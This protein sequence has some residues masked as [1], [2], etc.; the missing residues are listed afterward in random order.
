MK[1]TRL[2]SVLLSALI[3]S[4][5]GLAHA[6]DA[7]PAAAD[8]PAQP[9]Q[10]DS[11]REALKQKE[12]DATSEKNLQEVFQ[13][14]EKSYSLLKKGKVAMQY[15]V[16]YT[17][18]RD[19][20][21]DIAIAS[22]SSSLTRFRIEEDAQHTLTNTFDLSYGVKDNLTLNASLPLLTKVDTQSELNTTGLGD[23]GLGLRWQPVPLKRGL[24]TSTLFASLSTA[25]G[26]SPYDINVNQDLA[27]G[28]GY[29]SLSVGGSMSKVA[30]PIVLF[31]S[32][33]YSTNTK[34]GGLNQ[35]RGSRLLNSV[36]P[37]DGIG[38]SMG[39]A[40]SLNYDVSVTASYQQS[41]AF[42]TTY[43]FSNGEYVSTAASTSASLSFSLGLRTNPKRIV[44]V[45]LGY[46]LTEDT[47]DVT[48]GFSMPIDF[49]GSSED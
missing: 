29:Y 43:H 14:A 24:P 44:N 27:T 31:A 7:Q 12:G 36:E 47:P 4:V 41:Y 38:M 49:L 5:A 8:A 21:I 11:A 9:T 45:N 13:A 40:Y 19:S 35:L 16:D 34:A 46:G 23:I 37:G 28:K 18:Y 3:A 6:E 30:D 33:S 48:V 17:Y 22:N 25:T 15:D 39:L 1:N 42:S 2:H 26:D 20:R 32:G 10:A